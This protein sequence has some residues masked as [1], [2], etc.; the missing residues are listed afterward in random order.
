MSAPTAL[1]ALQEEREEELQYKKIQE[2]ISP[3]LKNLAGG[4]ECIRIAEAE[5]K[6]STKVL[7]DPNGQGWNVTGV[8]RVGE[9]SPSGE[10][11]Y[12]VF[13][14]CMYQSGAWYPNLLSAIQE[15]AQHLFYLPNVTNLKR[16][17]QNI[18]FPAQWVKVRPHLNVH[19]QAC[20]QDQVK[21]EASDL[22]ILYDE[23]EP[24]YR[25]LIEVDALCSDSQEEGEIRPFIFKKRALVA[26]AY[27]SPPP[28]AQPPSPIKRVKRGKKKMI[29]KNKQ[30]AQ[31]LL[32]RTDTTA[33]AVMRRPVQ[34]A[35]TSFAGVRIN[36]SKEEALKN[37]ST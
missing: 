32:P 23:P 28:R 35:D 14:K 18:R 7:H 37:K 36:S 16:S 10:Q 31:A 11:G 22:T 33:A 2:V 6:V 20:C 29:Q 8:L 13:V 9:Q 30:V 21:R 5:M 34:G 25:S 24:V 1:E 12:L 4:K 19:R 26:D 17:L 27:L 3:F 15:G